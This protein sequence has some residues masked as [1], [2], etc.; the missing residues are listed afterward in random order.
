MG[1]NQE[2]L[3][4]LKDY[5]EQVSKSIDGYSALLDDPYVKQAVLEKKMNAALKTSSDAVT[6]L[7]GQG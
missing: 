2:Q 5:A 1:L 7:R 3:D 4:A 6:E